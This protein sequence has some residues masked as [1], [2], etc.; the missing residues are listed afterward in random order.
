VSA[1]QSHGLFVKRSESNGN[2]NAVPPVLCSKYTKVQVWTAGKAGVAG[3][4]NTIPSGNPLSRFY[5]AHHLLQ[6]TI[7]AESTVVMPNQT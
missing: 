5:Q 1:R 4:S 6:V 7:V 2:T 3:V